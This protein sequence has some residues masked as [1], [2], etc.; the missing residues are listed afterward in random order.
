[1]KIIML[2]APGA[3]KGT[4]AKR[5]AEML[6]GRQGLPPNDFLPRHRD[7]TAAPEKRTDSPAS[8]KACPGSPAAASYIALDPAKPLGPKAEEVFS[9]VPV[10]QLFQS[11][12][13]RFAPPLYIFALQFQAHCCQIFQRVHCLPFC[14]E[15]ELERKI[16]D[17][18][19]HPV[20]SPPVPKTLQQFHQGIIPL[21]KK[22]LGPKIQPPV[23]I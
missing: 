12:P 3:G 4:Q 14:S 11:V 9:P 19:I 5:I 21:I 2:G 23:E 8:D 18:N 22:T 17:P 20:V 7:K 13:I 15:R 10:P 6:H 1:M 16:I